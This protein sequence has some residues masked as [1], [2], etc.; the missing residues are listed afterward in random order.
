MIQN[1]VHNQDLVVPDTKPTESQVNSHFNEMNWRDGAEILAEAANFIPGLGQ[2]IKAIV[3]LGKYSPEERLKDKQFKWVLEQVSEISNKLDLLN[4]LSTKD[5]PE[6][7]DVAAIINAAMEVSQKTA[8][9]KKRQLLKNAVVNSFS[10]VQYEEGLTLRLF[11]ILKDVEYGDCELLKRIKKESNPIKIK[12]L[13]NSD[14]SLTYHHLEVIGKLGLILVW[15]HN[16]DLP[17]GMSDE[18]VYTK[19]SELG[20]KFIRFITQAEE[21]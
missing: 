9:S 5:R 4:Q 1:M 15:N 17:L 18:H 11:S 7:A 3:G 6:P 19:I 13:A 16:P 20:E 14:N 2:A 12:S 10:I 21:N 8:G